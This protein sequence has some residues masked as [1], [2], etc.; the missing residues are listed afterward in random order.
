MSPEPQKTVGGLS[1]LCTAPCPSPVTCTIKV[2][3][4][5]LVHGVAVGDGADASAASPEER[6]ET[7]NVSAAR[8]AN[9]ITDVNTRRLIASPHV[10]RETKTLPV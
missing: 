5:E 8:N 10:R 9:R 6:T 7:A 3:E 4:V 1:E 2:H